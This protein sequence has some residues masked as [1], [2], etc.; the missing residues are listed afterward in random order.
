MSDGSMEGYR[1]GLRAAA[2]VRFFCQLIRYLK[3]PSEDAERKL[4]EAARK[5]DGIR[6]GMIG[7]THWLAWLER[8]LENL[9][10]RRR[11]VADTVWARLL[12][13]VREDQWQN[14]EDNK[15][16]VINLYD[17]LLALSPFAAD[18]LIFPGDDPHLIIPSENGNRRIE[19]RKLEREAFAREN[20]DPEHD[21]FV[22]VLKFKK[23]EPY[24]EPIWL[25]QTAYI[26]GQPARTGPIIKKAA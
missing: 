12:C 7:T 17:E 18:T 14:D 10:K 21:R 25:C 24:V 23:D 3:K 5:T 26:S 11:G 19:L 2:T 16:A 20:I 1:A 22:F 13:E 6:G 4:E 15:S 8:N 9:C